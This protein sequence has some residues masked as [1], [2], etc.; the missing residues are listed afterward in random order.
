[1]LGHGY[2]AGVECGERGRDRGRVVGAR[3]CGAGQRLPSPR[4]KWLRHSH[5]GV[6]GEVIGK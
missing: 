5:A 3:L 4:H 2:A 6:P 1:M